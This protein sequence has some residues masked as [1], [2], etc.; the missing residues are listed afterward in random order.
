MIKVFHF[1]PLLAAV[2]TELITTDLR[3][4]LIEIGI[5]LLSLIPVPLVD[6]TLA[7]SCFLREISY[8]L[9]GPFGV[10]SELNNEFLDLVFGLPNSVLLALSLP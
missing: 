9:L 1:A 5:K 4:Q 8:L 3:F 2:A 6:L 10:D 7:E